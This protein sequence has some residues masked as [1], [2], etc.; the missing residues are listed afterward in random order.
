MQ[1]NKN[2]GKYEH[3]LHDRDR[4]FRE[5]PRKGPAGMTN[6]SQNRPNVTVSAAKGGSAIPR[7]PTEKEPQDEETK[8]RNLL[9]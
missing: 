9:T 4:E 7:N 6:T 2:K 5:R 3:L 8:R 1:K